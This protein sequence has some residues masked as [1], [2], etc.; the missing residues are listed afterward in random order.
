MDILSTLE[1]GRWEGPFSEGDQARAVEALEAGRLLYLPRLSFIIDN[2]ERRFKT[3]AKPRFFDTSLI[4]I[5][6]NITLRMP[7]SCTPKRTRHL[8]VT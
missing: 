1:V 2:D 4:G 7:G 3:V 6:Q 5:S 8:T